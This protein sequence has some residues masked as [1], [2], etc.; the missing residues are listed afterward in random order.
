[1]LPPAPSTPT[2]ANCVAPVK[3]SSDIAQVCATLSP[4]ATAS[5]AVGDGV[6]A[7]ATPIATASRCIEVRLLVPAPMR[8][9]F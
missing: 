4:A 7:A 1:M 3:T 8:G 5:D 2:T 9:R 6:G